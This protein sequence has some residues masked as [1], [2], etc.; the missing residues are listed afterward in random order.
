MITTNYSRRISRLLRSKGLDWVA[1]ASEVASF[2]LLAVG[3]V[4][5]S[6][7]RIAHW[8]RGPQPP[9]PEEIGA[10]KNNLLAALSGAGPGPSPRRP[11]RRP[12]RPATG[13][14]GHRS[15][16]TPPRQGLWI[17]ARPGHRRASA[18]AAGAITQS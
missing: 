17:P 7:G 11:G 2:V 12:A 1:K 3:V 14:P 5:A 15:A 10:A 8:L 9:T 16:G 13:P 6:L 18:A 4:V